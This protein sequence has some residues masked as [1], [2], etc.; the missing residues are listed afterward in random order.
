MLAALIPQPGATGNGTAPLDLFFLRNLTFA[1]QSQLAPAAPPP[2]AVYIW[3]LQDSPQALQQLREAI[4]TAG[5]AQGVRVGYHLRLRS[6]RYVAEPHRD[7]ERLLE[8]KELIEQKL[9]Y[10]DSTELPRLKLLRFSDRQL[11]AMAD[12]I[13]SF[14]MRVIADE[15]AIRYA[16]QSIAPDGSGVHFLLVDPSRAPQIEVDPL[17]R[18][19]RAG[20]P[21]IR[22]WLDPFWARFY[23]GEGIT[24]IYVPEGHYMTPTMHAASKRELDAYM[25]AVMQQW[26]RPEFGTPAIPDQPLYLF[27]PH[28]SEPNYLVIAVLDQTQ[29]LPLGSRLDWLNKHLQVRHARAKGAEILAAISDV[30][31]EDEILE[32]LA[33]TRLDRDQRFQAYA[34]H[35]AATIAETTAQLTKALTDDLQAVLELSGATL[36]SLRE[37]KARLNELYLAQAQAQAL[38]QSAT[39]TT[40][41]LRSTL[42][43]VGKATE[44]LSTDVQTR[45]RNAEFAHEEAN[46]RIDQLDRLYQQ[47]RDRLNRR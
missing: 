1:D 2:S 13:R 20:D 42:A 39:D 44:A 12:Y 41:Q 7:R 9:E 30:L 15:Q 31:S 4:D 19:E 14:P 34:G 45:A 36:K 21:T 25:R 3:H 43:A 47:L 33:A 26:C 11:P 5:K 6:T 40:K 46:R 37:A 18:W 27:E 29:F 28:P 17:P 23:L 10:L 8:Q 16:F 32:H 22:F 38:E 35:S 24:Q